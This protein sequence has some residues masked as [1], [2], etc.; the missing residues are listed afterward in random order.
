MLLFQ[1]RSFFI[2]IIHRNQVF[3][4]EWMIS[5]DSLNNKKC[6][7]SHYVITKYNFINS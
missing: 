2:I 6:N 3:L 5:F 7:I 4:Q 1:L